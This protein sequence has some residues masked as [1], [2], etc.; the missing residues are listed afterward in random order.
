MFK[1]LF[2]ILWGGGH[3]PLLDA[4]EQ[5]ARMLE[6]VRGMVL[7]ASAVYWGKKQSAQERSALYDDDVQ[8]NRLQRS[9]RQAIITH[10]SGPAAVDVPYGL[11]MM[12]LVKDIERLGDYAKNLSEV[13]RMTGAGTLENDEIAEELRQIAQSVETLAREAAGIYGRDDRERAQELTV[14]GRSVAKRCDRLIEAIAASDYPASKA[15][16]ATLATRFY[17]RIEGHFLN[18]LSSI[19]MPLDELDHYDES[20]VAKD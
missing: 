10:L 11:L 18:L 3:H 4:A 12:S 15:V 19:L 17:K 2:S 14:E 13:Q 5:F 20:G 7:E 9:I 8:V 1:R 16:S 6:L